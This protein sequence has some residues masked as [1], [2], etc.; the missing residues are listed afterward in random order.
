MISLDTVIRQI[1]QLSKED[2][3]LINEIEEKIDIML[4]RVVAFDVKGYSIVV[5]DKL[6]KQIV[7][8][9][10]EKYDEGG[11][12]LEFFENFDHST[13]INLRTL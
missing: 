3:R 13:R 5:K 7:N 8:K 10:C 1:E 6:N 2:Q 12:A 11:W 4:L 9:L